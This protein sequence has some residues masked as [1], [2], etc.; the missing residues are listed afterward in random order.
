MARNNTEEKSLF[1]FTV[2]EHFQSVVAE[3]ARQQEFKTSL[4]VGKQRESGKW[5]QAINKIFK[6]CPQQCVSARLASST[7]SQNNTTN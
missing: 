1:W 6:A 3:K 5:D 4:A 2:S 7:A